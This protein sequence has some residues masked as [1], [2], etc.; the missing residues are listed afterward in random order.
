M[1]NAA[2]IVPIIDVDTHLS[3]PPDLWTSRLPQKWKD[4]APYVAFNSELGV[5]DWFCGDLR[6]VTPGFLAM[7]GHDEY[8]PNFP[9][10]YE[11]MPPGAWQSKARLEV[12]DEAGVYASVLYPNILA[13]YSWAFQEMQDQALAFACHSVYNEFVAE[14]ASEDRNRLIPTCVVPFW[15]IEESVRELRR[16]REL[17]ITALLFGWQYDKI[18]LPPIHDEHWEPILKTAEEL[19]MSINLHV[20]VGTRTEQ[21]TSE[22]NR[23]WNDWRS[24]D[25]AR[26]CSLVMVSNSEAI[27]LLTTSGLLE[28]YPGLK[29]VSV[30]SG[31]GYIPM[32]MESLDW[33]WMN[34][35]AFKDHPNQM[36][37][38]EAFRQY[39]YCSFWFE[40]QSLPLLEHW[41]DNV[42]FE[43]D[44]PHPTCLHPGAASIAKSPRDTAVENMSALPAEVVRK[45]LWDNPAKLYGVRKPIDFPAL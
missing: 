44:Y 36:M 26:L 40:K 21:D 11:E 22:V 12:M 15:D 34:G 31:F 45:V 13:F 10:S 20:A 14:F 32:L 6:L 2:E 7:A 16:S 23:A 19:G 39:M 42:M 38:S 24:A 28:R 37:P 18:G 43:S 35:G 25:Y 5:E 30:E 29:W 33:Q 8:T 3:E 27:A 9:K 41:S 17:G 4:Q 1:A